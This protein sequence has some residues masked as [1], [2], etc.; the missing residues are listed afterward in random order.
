MDR[1][2]LD[3][4]GWQDIQPGYDFRPQLDE[5]IRYT[6]AEDTRDEIL[7]RLLEQNRLQAAREAA[8]AAA[9]APKKPARPAPARKKAS[10]K[11]ESTLSLLPPDEPKK[12]SA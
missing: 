2:V 3:A 10:K 9:A 7:A 11:D 6:W 8:E 1:A 12:G 4:Y 5:S